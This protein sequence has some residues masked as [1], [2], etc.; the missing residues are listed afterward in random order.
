MTEMI[1]TFWCQAASLVFCI[2]LASVCLAE[3]A[4]P[5]SETAIR[6]LPDGRVASLVLGGVERLDVATP[7]S[8]FV[9]RIF[10]GVDVYDEPLPDVIRSGDQVV[11]THK[12]GVPR[13]T[14]R[15][16]EAQR[17]LSLHLVR[18][19]GMPQD[20]GVSLR[21][22]ANLIA[23]LEVLG[24]DYMI[25]PSVQDNRLAVSW[26]YLWHRN[27]E[28]PFGAFALYAAE[29]ETDADLALAGIWATEP[30]PRPAG[31]ASWTE[32]DVLAW[33]D[34]YHRRFAALSEIT[35]SASS[36]EE[37]YW[38]TEEARKAG[39]RRVYLH[40]DTWRGEYWPRNRTHVDVNPAVFPGG[41]SDLVKYAA[42]LHERHMLLRLH[43]VS[44]GIGWYDPERIVTH[45]DCGLA[46]W[47]GGVLEAAVGTGDTVLRFRPNPGTAV[48]VHDK[49]FLRQSYNMASDYVRIGE[50]IVRVGEFTD[51]DKPVWQLLGCKR[52][53]G[54]TK[55][56]DHAAGT[57]GAGLFA[58]YHSNLVPDLDSELLTVMA[59]EYAELVNE[60]R[61][62]HL[63]FDGLEIHNQ[64][65]WGGRKFSNLVY[66]RVAHPVTS[67]SSQ[68]KS[69]SANFEMRFSK[70]RRMRELDYHGVLMPILLAD[71]RDATSML[72]THF[73]IQAMLRL[74]TRRV[75]LQKPEPM[76][77]LTREILEGHG[78]AD[79]VFVLARR[80]IEMMPLLNSQDAETLKAW[81]SPN[82]SALRQGGTHYESADVLVL[83][84]EAM[85]WIQTRVMMRESG[86]VPWRFGQE[87]GAIGPRQYI[88]PGD[89]LD[90]VNPYKAQEP[91]FILH[92]LSECVEAS[93]NSP[94]VAVTEGKRSIEDDY[95]A[96]VRQ[97]GKEMK[98][99][100]NVAPSDSSMLQPLAVDVKNQRFTTFTQDK[101]GVVLRAGNPTSTP[102]WVEE[103]L[104]S[105]N[106]KV[107]MAGGRGLAL[108]V[109]GDGSG[110]VLVIQLHGRGV[111]DYVVKIDFKGKREIVIPNGEAAWANGCW[112]YRI[113]AKQFDYQQ[114]VTEF[115]MGFGYVPPQTTPEVRVA[116]LRTLADK[117]TILRNPVIRIG[118]GSLQVQ[119]DIA[120]GSYLQY[121]GGTTA[122]VFDSNWN[123]QADLPIEKVGFVMPEGQAPV[124]VD[125]GAGAPRPWITVQF[126]TRGKPVPLA[127][128]GVTK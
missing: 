100:V 115:S 85:A 55:P 68:G 38:L 73:C 10:D 4:G 27:P 48:P 19:E 25:T 45:V 121:Q 116:R 76:F 106:R 20:R 47:G 112:G 87:H 15:I 122:Q 97:A 26:Q 11:V 127:Q 14:F 54:G 93:S 123:H 18:V 110:A 64:Y 56:T 107:S 75:V 2:W 79:D 104:P 94:H 103:N 95:D 51:L 58:P 72:D 78:Q 62:D 35:L 111:R 98:A 59:G 84:D 66:E 1:S 40:T 23:P 117:P 86:D 50:E 67:S 42:Y 92:V 52:G 113:G 70:I 5:P 102:T 8:G 31:Q 114:P 3:V 13:F 6:F 24:L 53:Y 39:I 81:T 36:Q 21:F 101:D 77:G 118:T 109:I 96:G 124:R 28:D 89:V 108:D 83:S 99:G 29:H 32:A 120:T 60:A 90:L 69:V 7:G 12:S 43:Y 44:G 91:G 57:D 34:A 80:W 37:L 125:V 128:A 17:H 71:H 16:V 65:P 105:W 63:H 74:G 49:R 30:I 126:V 33:V 46:T 61:L 82:S 9:L 22:E 119:G 41:R 88:Q